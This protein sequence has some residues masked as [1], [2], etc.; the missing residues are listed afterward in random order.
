MHLETLWLTDF[1]NYP[2]AE[3][4]P[5]PAG[6]TLVTGDNGEGKTNLLEA[7]AYLATLRS[8]RGN[9][10]DAMVRRDAGR[11]SAIV[12]AAASR[13]GRQLKVEAEL[14]SAG[15]DRVQINGQPVRRARDLLGAIQVTVFSP[16]DLS[17]VKGGPQL[18]REYLDD[19]LIALHPRHDVVVG[20]V[21]RV[22]KQRNALLKSAVSS[23]SAKPGRSLD[24]DVR[25][26]LDVWDTKLALA[27]EQLA[28]ARAQLVANLGPLVATC[29][30]V[31]AAASARP[32]GSQVSLEYRP[33]WQGPLLDALHAARNEDL[34]RGVTTTGPHRDDL[35]SFV[36]NMPARTH[37][38]QGEQR[39]LAL[40][41]R[42]AG[43]L[44]VAD[45]V[46]STPILLLDDVFS[47]LDPYRSDALLHSL[48]PG[49]SILTTAG[50]L[51]AGALVEARFK[52]E[53]AKILR[54]GPEEPVT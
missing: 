33:S 13:Q 24:D 26:T 1:R 22:L 35:D 42:L 44:L 9:P 30:R 16:D 18:R 28:E 32:G 46:G 49:Q 7:I 12:R 8:L 48:P 45:R 5:S 15:R 14:R 6:I 31:L 4:E 43:H 25:L 40:A 54:T 2:E 17:L 3:F 21:E 41:L 20:E 27:G 47:E 51:P 38:S 11:D 50:H 53:G 34:R 52:I 29:Y 19:L 37:A 10:P 39:C 36:A 23:G